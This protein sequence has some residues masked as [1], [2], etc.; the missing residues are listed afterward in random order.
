MGR[1]IRMVPPNWE[2]PKS[3]CTHWPKCN[4]SFD[5]YQ[6]MYD[7]E[8]NSKAEEWLKNCIDWMNGTHENAKKYKDEY[9]YFWMYGGEP[10][11]AKYYRAYK[12]EEATWFQMYETVSEGT[13]LT[14]PFK[15]K[16]ELIDYLVENGDFWS[17]KKK[18]GGWNRESA[19]KFVNSGWFPSFIM[20][21]TEKGTKIISAE[22]CAEEKD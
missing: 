8:F 5:H 10:P 1:E 20:N 7:D 3:E 9:P 21:T 11:D 17:Q 13:P 6:P 19:V 15:T 18:A 22:N 14:P 2:H 12:D 16:E 4:E